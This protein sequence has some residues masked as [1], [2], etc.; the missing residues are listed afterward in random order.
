MTVT[1]YTCTDD[2]RKLDKTITAI[3]TAIT[4]EPTEDCSIINPRLILTYNSSRLPCNYFY[5]SDFGRY[6]FVTGM[7]VMPGGLIDLTG[8]IDVLKTYSASIK[9]CDATI[10]RSESVGGPT[11]YPDNKLPILPNRFDVTS[12]KLEGNQLPQATILTPYNYLLQVRG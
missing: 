2:P 6:Y 9:A 3:G 4:A 11:Q 7:T 10:I 5:I 12:V 1:L 8:K